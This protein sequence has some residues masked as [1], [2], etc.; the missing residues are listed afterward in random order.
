[1]I[2]T[3]CRW[4]AWPILAAVFFVTLSPVAW[5]P[6]TGAPAEIERFAAFAVLGAVFCAG[7]PKH[8]IIV[9]ILLVAVAGSL[10]AL[11][12]LVPTRHGRISD[13]CLKALGAITGVFVATRLAMWCPDRFRRNA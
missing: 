2:S 1:M 10:E 9:L 12:Q 8:R 3:L 7:Y 6:V 13:A 11:Q 5:R 4:I